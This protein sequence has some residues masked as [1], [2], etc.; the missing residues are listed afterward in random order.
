MA[1]RVAIIGGGIAGI[2]AAS[3]LT[4]RGY[5]TVLIEK[6]TELG[7][8]VNKWDRLFPTKTSAVDVANQLKH[9]LPSQTKVLVNTTVKRLITNNNNFALLLS[10]DT[11]EKVDATLIATGFKTFDARRKEEYGYGIYDNVLTSVDLEQMFRQNKIMCKN[12]AAPKRVAFIHCVGSRDEKVNN[13]HCSRVCCITAVKQAIELKQMY[14]TC[15]VFCF[16]MDLRMFGRYYEDFYHDAQAKYGITFIRGRLSEAAEDHNN[17]LV[18]KAEDTLVGKPLKLTV[19]MLVLMVGMEAADGTADISAC[20]DIKQG[21]DGFLL[22]ADAYLHNN[23]TQQPGI[24]VAGTCTS[25][26]NIPETLAD[27]RAAVV[28]IDDFLKGNIE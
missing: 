13:R 1:K 23:F 22:P 7:G 28:A 4:S 24:F 3:L 5:D 9:K 16:Y 25:P 14:P 8:N 6:E 21:D 19:D 27:A 10:D 26:K 17:K 12:G 20:M 2:E 18:L 11:L 15:E